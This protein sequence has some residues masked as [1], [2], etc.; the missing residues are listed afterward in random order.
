MSLLRN[1]I[2]VGAATTLVGV[3]LMELSSESPLKTP[4]PSWYVKATLLTGLAGALGYALVN[5]SYTPEALELNAD[6]QGELTNL[7]RF[8]AEVFEATKPRRRTTLT[9]TRGY[10][11]AFVSKDGDRRVFADNPRPYHLDYYRNSN[12]NTEKNA[13]H[14]KGLPE[15]YH[16][17]L[18]KPNR[19]GN[20]WQ[21]RM[22]SPHGDGW[23][24]D[25]NFEKKEMMGDVLHWYNRQ[26]AIPQKEELTPMML[27]LKQMGGVSEG[28]HIQRIEVSPMVIQY[29]YS[30]KDA[31]GTEHEP[32][33]FAECMKSRSDYVV[34]LKCNGLPSPLLNFVRGLIYIGEEAGNNR[35]VN[36]Y[37]DDRKMWV[38]SKPAWFKNMCE[39]GITQLYFTSDTWDENTIKIF[40]NEFF[41]FSPSAQTFQVKLPID[42]SW[43]WH[44]PRPSTVRKMKEKLLAN[45]PTATS[46]QIREFLFYEAVK[47]YQ[48]QKLQYYHDMML[49]DS[50]CS[51]W[52]GFGEIGEAAGQLMCRRFK[53]NEK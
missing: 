48:P 28:I 36:R 7:K 34:E 24:T 4:K 11:P 30:G 37:N 26:I 33:M 40:N 46:N 45:D 44:T 20:Y 50:V 49:N 43:T 10:D 13:Y 8:M 9:W 42:L 32:T 29:F 15:G 6:S 21:L 52:Q 1:S 16:I 5:N 22:K 19:R 38:N 12:W 17:H 14:I 18:W 47:K 41:R 31:K 23:Q 27:A 3:G 51:H 35:N 2:I 53:K 39:Q 25:Y